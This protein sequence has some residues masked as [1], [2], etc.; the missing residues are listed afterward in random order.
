MEKNRTIFAIENF[1]KEKKIT[2]TKFAALLNVDPSY[3]CHILKGRRAPSLFIL[4]KLSAI[5]KVPLDK[6]V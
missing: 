4:K 6:L 2:R 3:I 5:F 1:C